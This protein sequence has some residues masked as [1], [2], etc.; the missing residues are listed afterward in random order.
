MDVFY[1]VFDSFLGNAKLIQLLVDSGARVNTSDKVTPANDC[2]SV[3]ALCVL[4]A[5]FNRPAIS[6]VERLSRASLCG[7]IWAYH[8][9]QQAA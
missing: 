7:I 9:H 1:L 4:L 2:C 6:P 8:R 3:L 5:L